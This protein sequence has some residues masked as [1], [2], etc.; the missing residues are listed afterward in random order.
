M[1]KIFSLIVVMAFM[2]YAL[3]SFSNDEKVNEKLFNTFHETSN[4]FNTC[5]IYYLMMK[6]SAKN[7]Y[8]YRKYKILSQNALT[9]ALDV[10]IDPLYPNYI[11]V[12]RIVKKNGFSISR[13][14]VREWEDHNKSFEHMKTHY[15]KIC[16]K[17]LT[18]FADTMENNYSKNLF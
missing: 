3:W 4:E 13:E 6:K 2:P 9:F 1:K 14:L 15:E 11:N 8:D 18:N 16:N 7:N 10:M 5:G 12:K 17:K